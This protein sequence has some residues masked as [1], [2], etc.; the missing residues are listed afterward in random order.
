MTIRVLFVCMGNICRSPLAEGV[1]RTEVFAAGLDGA[2][3]ADSAGTGD[4]HVG[5]PPHP[6]SRKVALEKGFSIDDLRGRQVTPMDFSVFDYI[7]AMDH[8]NVADLTEMAP[9]GLV[10]KIA[11]FMSFSSGVG[12]NETPEEIEDPYGRDPDAYRAALTL[13]EDAARGLLHTI[14]MNDLH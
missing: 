2:I 9:K 12:R 1:F 14:R 10:H 8:T 7:I 3:E 13:C 6:N 4:W 11:R 5:D